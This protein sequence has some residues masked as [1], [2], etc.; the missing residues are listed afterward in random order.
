M[1]TLGPV[2]LDGKDDEDI[3]DGSADADDEQ[4][5]E[6]DGVEGRTALQPT[7]LLVSEAEMFVPDK[8]LVLVVVHLAHRLL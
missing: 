4:D 1:V 6:E 8:G 5:D 7:N 2:Q 3:D